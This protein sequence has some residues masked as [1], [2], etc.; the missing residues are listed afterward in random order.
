MTTQT[1][2]WLRM[3][4]LQMILGSLLMALGIVAF[5]ALQGSDYWAAGIIVMLAG[6]GQIGGA[7][8]GR[9]HARRTEAAA[10]PDPCQIG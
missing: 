4:R 6:A 7:V 9:R 8:L 2:R 5:I 10:V 1:T 3:I